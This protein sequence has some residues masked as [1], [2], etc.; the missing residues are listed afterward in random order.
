MT[1]GFGWFLYTLLYHWL[2]N[3][4]SI[5][6]SLLAIG[7]FENGNAIWNEQLKSIL[8]LASIAYLLL[9]IIPTIQFIRNYRFVQ[10][11]RKTGLSKCHVD[12]RIFVQRFGERMGI[13]KPVR[14]YI[15]DLITSPVTIGFLKP[16]ILMPIAAITNLTDKQVEAVLLHELAHIRRYD[17]FINLL[18]NCIRTI[19]Y[20]NPFV[21]SF[22][23]TIE[24]ER[25]KSCDEIVM[26]FEY[27]PHGYASALLVLERNNFVKQTIA[28]AASGQRN[29]LLH[30]IERILGIEKRKTPD[31]RKLGGLLAGLMCVIA[32]NALFFFSSPVIQSQSLAFTAF[33]SPFYQLVSDGKISP[34]TDKPI[35]NK[36]QETHTLVMVKKEMHQKART[37]RSTSVAKNISYSIKDVKLDLDNTAPR[38]HFVYSTPEIKNNFALADQKMH[39]EPTLKKAEIAQVN[40]AVAA[41]KKV[42]EEGQWKQVEKNIADVLTEVEKE[43]LKEKYYSEVDKINWKSLEERLRL[44]YDRI[45]W[46]KVNAQLNTAITNIKL[47]SLTKVYNS[48]LDDLNTAQTWMTQNQVECIP[49]TDLKMDEVKIQT[50][51]IQKQLDRIKAIKGKKIIHL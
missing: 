27:D 13:R 47:D 46:N 36:R 43:N 19:L 45:N 50:Q 4:D 8:P 12:L 25:E 9:L 18:I 34:V 16:I 17:Y 35:E 31:F 42:L 24:R 2:I 37:E 5:K 32:L 3:P 30:R 11:I 44:S 39:V 22:A 38:Y 7:S 29:D 26:Q 10:I 20:F 23:K 48:A 28:V 15:S 14:L 21:K 51:R 49:D 6:S 33:S 40:E 41:T 1:T